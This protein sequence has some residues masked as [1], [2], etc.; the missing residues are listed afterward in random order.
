MIELSVYGTLSTSSAAFFYSPRK[1]RSGHESHNSDATESLIE[2]LSKITL[3]KNG[4]RLQYE[5]MYRTS[6][7]SMWELRHAIESS[8]MR[9]LCASCVPFSLSVLLLPLLLPAR[10][11]AHLGE[12]D[13]Q[14]V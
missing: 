2:K 8:H 10:T 7:A 5:C 6:I 4:F 9:I 13:Y 11:S 12:Q 3:A 1:E 14:T